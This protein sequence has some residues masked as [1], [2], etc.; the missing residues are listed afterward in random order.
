MVSK[1]TP[2]TLAAGGA[3]RIAPPPAVH[4]LA[5]AAGPRI[6]WA[7][8][9]SARPALLVCAG[10]LSHLDLDWRAPAHGRIHRVLAGRRR[11]IRYDRPGTGL[12]DR[13]AAPVTLE[14]ETDIL[15]RVVEASGETRVGLLAAGLA[16]PLAIAYAARR[17]ERVSHVVLFG[18]AVP[19]LA[20]GAE[21]RRLAGLTEALSRLIRADWGVAAGALAELHLPAAEP[22]ERADYADY[23]RLAAGPE[24]AAGLLAG[25]AALDVSDLIER[26]RVPT[27]IL[28]RRDSRVAGV[29]AARLLAARIRGARL[30]L[31]DGSEQLVSHGDVEAVLAEITGFLDPAISLLTPRELEILALA[32]DGLS[33]RSIAER[34]S[35]SE[36]TVARH[37]ANVFLKLD[38]SSRSAAAAYARRVGLLASGIAEPPGPRRQRLM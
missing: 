14:A 10:W 27:L 4:Y 8:S 1:V 5:S 32:A 35:L 30:S 23:Q 37:M 29:A 38:V 20:G 28:H 25:L 6:A 9:G 2:L 34:V 11:L 21:A 36:H 24:T 31:L 18:P 33:N 19:G 22:A 13:I 17:P 15:D 12:A 26:V 7:A 3:A 16:A